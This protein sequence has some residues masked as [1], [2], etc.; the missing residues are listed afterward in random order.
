MITPSPVTPL[1]STNAIRTV[2]GR[3]SFAWTIPFVESAPV[4]ASTKASTAGS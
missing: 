1:E 3:V 4:F 2:P